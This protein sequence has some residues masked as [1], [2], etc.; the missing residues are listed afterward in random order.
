M[1]KIIPLLALV[2]CL[3]TVGAVVM[4][5]ESNQLSLKAGD[6]VYVCNCG[7]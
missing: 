3:S 5:A 4:A 2:F 1:K 6:Q 7:K